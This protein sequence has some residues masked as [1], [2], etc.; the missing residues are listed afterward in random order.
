MKRIYTKCKFC[1]SQ[2]INTEDEVSLSSDA[3]LGD[4]WRDA[5][6]ELPADGEQVIWAY[7]L[8]GS[9]A[10]GLESP[11]EY[12]YIYGRYYEETEVIRLP[13]SDK[14]Y[15]AKWLNYWRRIDPPAFA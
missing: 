7:L 10:Q 1:G 12:E 14:V 8:K 2:N 3:V 4:G 15:K 9:R 6:K 13:W 11:D 5:R